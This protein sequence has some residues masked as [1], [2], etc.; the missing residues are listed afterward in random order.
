[1]ALDTTDFEIIRTPDGYYRHVC[2]DQRLLTTGWTSE[3]AARRNAGMYRGDPS[4]I[5]KCRERY[6]AVFPASNETDD[7]AP[8]RA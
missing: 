6:E 5:E 3:I 4:V 2:H 8:F 7:R 1:M